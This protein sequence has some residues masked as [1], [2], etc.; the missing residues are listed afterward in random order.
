MFDTFAN[1]KQKYCIVMFI[2]EG[3]YKDKKKDIERLGNQK[4]VHLIVQPCPYEGIEF[5]YR[6]SFDFQSSFVS[7]DKSFFWQA[8]AV[9]SRC[10]IKN[11]QLLANT[12][13]EFL[14]AVLQNQTDSVQALAK[15]VRRLISD[16][17]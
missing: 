10:D 3:D 15:K 4:N 12:Q 13:H 8:I 7:A 9:N 6:M 16:N 1:I 2:Q 5:L 14:I 11:L 17:I